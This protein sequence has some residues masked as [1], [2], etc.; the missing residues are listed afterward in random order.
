MSYCLNNT[1]V[2]MKPKEIESA[3]SLARLGM[4]FHDAV[5]EVQ[6]SHP[7]CEKY[8]TEVAT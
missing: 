3:I 1:N 2:A 4:S 5:R 7:E 6:Q 8:I